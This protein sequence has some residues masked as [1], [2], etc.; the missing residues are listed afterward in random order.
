MEGFPVMIARLIRFRLCLAVAGAALAGYRLAGGNAPAAALMVLAG[1]FL[2]A[3]CGSI[4]NQV[5]ERHSDALMARTRLRPL[6]AGR[7]GP[8]T[9]LILG[10]LAGGSGTLVLLPLSRA[11]AGAGLLALLCYNGLYTPLKKHTTLALLPGAL[12]GSLAPAIGWLAGGGLPADFHIVL[13]SGLLFLWQIPHFWLLALKHGDDLRRAG[14]FPGL[15]MIPENRARRLIFVWAFALIAAAPL[16]PALNVVPA[17]P[18]GLLCLAAAG[19][20]LVQLWRTGRHIPPEPA[21][22]TG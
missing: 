10:L 8:G 6:P 20:P 7:L 21:T 12:C 3:A 16:L 4:L 18:A 15:P 17:W 1:V 5:Q 11:A 9:A 22:G 14:L 13:V 2:L 19:W